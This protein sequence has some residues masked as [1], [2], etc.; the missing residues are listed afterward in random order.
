MMEE[1]G[2]IEK[3]SNKVNGQYRF[4]SHDAVVAKLRPSIVKNRIVVVPSVQKI[5]QEG[6]RTEMCLDVWFIN[7]ERPEDRFGITM[8]GYGIDPSD[9]G[10][11]KAVSYAFKYALLKTFL[12]ETG[13][14]P[15]NDTK[16]GY[17]PARCLEFDLM[18][19]GEF[20][21]EELAKMKRF[22]NDIAKNT[23]KHVEDVKREAIKRMPEFLN[24]LKNWK[25]K[26]EQ[27]DQ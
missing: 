15:D 7:P 6:N 14:D 20:G 1:V 17:E 26:K 5:V 10:P 9:K 18:I 2:Y 13:D 22:L 16:L 8:P 4:V 12:L 27:D 23:N 25:H 11:G 21:K 19:P 3:G 24:A